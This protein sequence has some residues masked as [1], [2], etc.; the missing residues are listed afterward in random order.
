MLQDTRVQEASSVPCSGIQ[1]TGDQTHLNPDKL[2]FLLRL[3]RCAKFPDD[4][5]QA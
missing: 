4:H 1:P 2:C 5:H 3:S